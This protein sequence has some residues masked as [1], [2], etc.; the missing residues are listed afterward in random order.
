VRGPGQGADRADR[1]RGEGHRPHLG[2]RRRL[3]RPGMMAR[4]P[5]ASRPS[6]MKTA[7]GV[8]LVLLVL[9]T[10]LPLGLVMGSCPNAQAAC[11][12]AGPGSCAAVL[13]AALVFLAA[14]F[15]RARPEVDSV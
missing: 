7:A 5:N 12:T 1:G 8:A 4:S 9:L 2:P 13:L 10:A 14:L 15:T 6:P 3:R 11:G